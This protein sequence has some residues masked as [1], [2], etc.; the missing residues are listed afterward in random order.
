MFNL[1]LL[2]VFL[3]K[4][5][6][7]GRVFGLDRQT[8]ISIGIQLFNAAVLAAVLAF[9]LYRPVSSFLKKRREDIQKQLNDAAAAKDEAEKLKLLYE[10]KLLQAEAEKKNIIAEARK[11]AELLT[12]Q[13]L[14]KAQG[15][16]ET[17]MEETLAAIQ[18]EKDQA[19]NAAR[20]QIIE[21]AALMAEKIISR[22]LDEE[23]QNKLFEEV[24]IELE[25]Q[26]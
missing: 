25:K 2:T 13:L 21:I 19:A 23:A 18:K 16:A 14:A 5:A 12:E 7:Q 6:P 1:N 11:Q 26:L 10:E 20:Q 15:N 8:A 9:F 3:L 17:L 22:S 24:L 4:T